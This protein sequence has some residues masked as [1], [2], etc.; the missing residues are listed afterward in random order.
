[1][2][3][4]SALDKND[5]DKSGSTTPEHK[6]EKKH[7]RRSPRLAPLPEIKNEALTEAELRIRE[8]QRE[9]RRRQF[10]EKVY[11]VKLNYLNRF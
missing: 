5:S 6:E 4:R 10:E 8:A 3:P 2:R 9:E 11:F 1:M 7:R